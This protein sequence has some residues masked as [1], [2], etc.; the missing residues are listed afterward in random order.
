MAWYV[1]GGQMTTFRSQFSPSSVDLGAQ[2]QVVRFSGKQA[3]LPSEPGTG[4]PSFYFC[5]F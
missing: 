2:T 4:P 3:P 1:H 5:S